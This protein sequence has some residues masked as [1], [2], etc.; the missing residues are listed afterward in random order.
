MECFCPI[1]NRVTSVDTL[2]ESCEP[3]R[4]VR[5]RETGF[6]F[7]ANP[8]EY[9]QLVDEFAWEKT[10][11]AE[12][13]RRRQTEPGV[14]IVS[15]LLKAAKRMLFPGRSP[16]F[17][18]ARSVLPREGELHLLDIGCGRGSLLVEIH[19]RYA[20]LGVKVVPY[21]IE[22]SRG[23]AATSGEAFAALGGKVVFAGALEGIA[24][25]AP[26]DFDG[27]FMS[28]FLEHER[29]PLSLLQKLP[30]IIKTTASIILKVPNYNCLNR[31]LRGKKWCGFRFPD[32]VNYFTPRTL[33]ILAAEAGLEVARQ[34]FS[35]RLP[36]SDSMYAVLRRRPASAV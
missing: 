26:D 17:A 12:K 3:W 22:I 9:S 36:L 8:P 34:R 5:C 24:E 30:G 19:G 7:L 14:A 32:H 28:S 27:V 20:K 15:D 16:F 25:F 11:L 21:G 13:E 23:L 35:D 33:A 10:Y 31:L 4:L 1:L 6:V 2:D 18:I 29:R